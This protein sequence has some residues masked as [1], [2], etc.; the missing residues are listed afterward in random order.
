M[1]HG[2]KPSQG[3]ISWETSPTLRLLEQ[4]S[5]QPILKVPA[6][7]SIAACSPPLRQLPITLS[8]KVSCHPPHSR[9]PN[10][11]R[12]DAGHLPGTK[13][14]S[15]FLVMHPTQCILIE[16]RSGCLCDSAALQSTHVII[17]VRTLA[18]TAEFFRSTLNWIEHLHSHF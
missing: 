7:P 5:F 3:R 1:S 6:G 13:Q 2:N 17:Q 18:T 15:S 4:V 10:L 14:A 16:T 9:R 11:F 8:A 12:I